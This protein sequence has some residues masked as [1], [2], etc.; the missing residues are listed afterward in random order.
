MRPPESTVAIVGAGPAGVLTAVRLL[1]A[2]ARARR[3]IDPVLIDP[4]AEVGHGTAY[5]TPEPKHLLN[6]PAGK[7]G[8]D[9][10][11][12]S[13]FVRW[14]SERLRRPVGPGEFLPR[15]HFGDYLGALLDS[16]A[17]RSGAHWD[18]VRE[19][20]VRLERSEAG[21]TLEL[22]SGATLAASAAVLAVG[23][24]A[25]DCG[26]APRQLRESPRFVADPWARDGGFSSD[27][28]VLFV[29][30]GLTMVDLAIQL[31][32]PDR[33]LHAVS[34]T[35][36]LPRAHA[37]RPGAP[38]VAP[39]LAGLGPDEVWR[40]VSGGRSWRSAVDCLRPVASALWRG[41][42]VAEQ[43]R[44]LAEKSRYWNVL[45]HRMAPVVAHRLRRI[46]R[47]G[48]LRLHTGE[49]TGAVEDAGGLLVALSD[50]QVLRVGLV[51]NCTGPKL[52]LRAGGK[53]VPGLFADG[54]AMPGPHGLGIDTA[55]DGRVL[56]RTGP[57]TPLWTLGAP[58]V[59]TLWESTAIPEIRDQ[60]DAVAA[61]VL[62]FVTTRKT[63]TAGLGTLP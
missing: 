28:D 34:R 46:R 57:D 60:A 5:R 61:S 29:G 51:V 55:A 36:L 48:R 2:A 23:P 3:R 39:D 26:W 24:C 52:D 45:R 50:G 62:S 56:A 14:S 22:A 8:A 49:V 38:V 54:L 16:T 20:V 37:S 44:F 7:L 31:D 19:R 42:S 32:R 41:F 30:T 27:G 53:L 4:A 21:V 11:D 10:A 18:Y 9:P 12:P 13:G 40:A 17:R 59:G 43:E 35:G 1:D 33:T 47:D 6:T 15:R 58:R 63:P 25:P